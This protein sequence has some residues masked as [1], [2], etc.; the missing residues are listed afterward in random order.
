VA[1]KAFHKAIS[2]ILFGWNRNLIK[3]YMASMNGKL[4]NESNFKLGR[5]L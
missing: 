4:S 3:K 2:N 5:F 1:Q